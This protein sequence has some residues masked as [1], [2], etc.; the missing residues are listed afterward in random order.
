M[1]KVWDLVRVW[2]LGMVKVWDLVRVWD[3][4]KV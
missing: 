4:V 1:V 2:G 3:L